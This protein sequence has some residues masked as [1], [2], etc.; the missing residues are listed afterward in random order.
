MSVKKKMHALEIPM[1]EAKLTKLTAGILN[2]TKSNL[3]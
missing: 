3:K 2:I 1:Y